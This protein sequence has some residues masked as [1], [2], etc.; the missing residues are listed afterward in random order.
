[1]NG[2]A[3]SATVEILRHSETPCSKIT[4]FETGASKKEKSR[5]PAQ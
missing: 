4:L 3:C 5:L 2:I 1:M